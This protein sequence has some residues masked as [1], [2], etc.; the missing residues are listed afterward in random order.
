M[1]EDL[2]DDI[3]NDSLDD[4]EPVNDETQLYEHFRVVVDKGQEM[5]RVDK[6]LFDR[7]T[8]ASRIGYRRRPTEVL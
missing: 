7:L 1:I 4:V 8:N 5:L 3:E 6:Y 2:S